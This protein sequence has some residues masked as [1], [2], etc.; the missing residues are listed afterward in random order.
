MLCYVILHVYY[1]TIYIYIY[2]LEDFPY[3]Y[4]AA[5]EACQGSETPGEAGVDDEDGE[6]E[7]RET[8]RE[9][10]KLRCVQRHRCVGGFRYR[11]H[12]TWHSLEFRT[13]STRDLAIVIDFHVVL[14]T[15][16]ERMPPV[17]TT[18]TASIESIILGIL[19]EHG[20]RVRQDMGLSVALTVN[21][22]FF[23]GSMLRFPSLPFD[24]IREAY[25]YLSL[26]MY[27]CMYVHMYV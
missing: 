26:S 13:K 15:I 23:L 5:Q 20:L 12:T 27:V 10:C 3:E 22:T 19:D 24:R 14:M 25:L 4:D 1:S 6:E 2:A 17:D 18:D 21:A 11:A 7:H 16:R 9:G 8:S